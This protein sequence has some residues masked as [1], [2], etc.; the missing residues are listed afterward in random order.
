M[1]IVMSILYLGWD[2]TNASFICGITVLL[3]S[4]IYIYF[5][6]YTIRPQ[7]SWLSVV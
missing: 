7:I 6:I 5:E 3:L 2:L 1:N 4:L